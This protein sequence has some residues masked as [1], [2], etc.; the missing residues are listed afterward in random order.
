MNFGLTG[1]ASGSQALVE[2]R[3]I[4]S[5]SDLCHVQLINPTREAY[6]VP[7]SFDLSLY[8]NMGV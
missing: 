6:V 1:L 4:F 8:R 5:L 3:L 2:E 7:S